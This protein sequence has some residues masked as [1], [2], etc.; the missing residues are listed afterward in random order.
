ML[1]K[2]IN[3]NINEA[4]SKTENPTNA[5]RKMNLVIQLMSESRIKS[6]EV[7]LAKE[8]RVHFL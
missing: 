4:E 3:V 5:F 1:N 8:E 7:V 6:D 2:N